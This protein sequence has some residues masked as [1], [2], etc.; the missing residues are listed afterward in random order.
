[1]FFGERSMV[2]RQTE[3]KDLKMTGYG[4]KKRNALTRHE[5][6]LFFFLRKIKNIKTVYTS[7]GARHSSPD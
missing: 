3:L 4:K 1:M 6:L 7:F 5:K 2:K